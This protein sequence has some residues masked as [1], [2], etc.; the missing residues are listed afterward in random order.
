MKRKGRGRK[1]RVCERIEDL[2]S[3]EVVIMVGSG[4]VIVK[5]V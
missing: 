5:S 1:K 3:G 4:S 2:T